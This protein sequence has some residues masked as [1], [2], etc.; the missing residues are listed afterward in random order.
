MNLYD[1]VREV[2]EAEDWKVT[3]DFEHHDAEF[4]KYSPAG[5]DFLFSADMWGIIENVR[6]YA[7]NFDP[8]Y[9][10]A[11]HFQARLAGRGDVPSLR[12]L[13]DDADAIDE[14]LEELACALE[15]IDPDE[16]DT[17]SEEDEDCEED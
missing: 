2:A 12:V 9:H 1:K 7:N 4:E 14:M 15:E 11:L 5:E 13:L 17:E 10:V 8:E 16:F 6:D 3:Y